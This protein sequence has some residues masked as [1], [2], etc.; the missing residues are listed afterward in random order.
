MTVPPS[1]EAVRAKAHEL[2]ENE[3]RPEGQ[4]DGYWSRASALLIAEAEE[5]V[6]PEPAEAEATA[7]PPVLGPTA[8]E[9]IAGGLQT[10]AAMAAGAAHLLSELFG[11]RD[12]PTKPS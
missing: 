8:V 4:G 3:G 2:W 10:V 7:K 9:V 11:K 5:T 12:E 6:V 1:D